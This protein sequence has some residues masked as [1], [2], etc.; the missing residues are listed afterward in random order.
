ME[1]YE[2]LF[3]RYYARVSAVVR[4]RLGDRLRLGLESGDIIQDSMIQAFRGLENY[5]VKDNAAFID[6]MAG[7]VENR[8]RAANKHMHAAKRDRAHEVALDH[9]RTAVSSGTLVLEPSA[10]LLS[11]SKEVA[12]NEEGRRMWA[13][14]EELKDRYRRVIV[15][16]HFEG[17]SWEVVSETLECPSPDAARMLYARATVELKKSLEDD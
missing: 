13:A 17:A 5:T 9:I 4:R 11:P 7:I 16:R 8:I 15:L 1:A 10:G 14:L 12:R 6:W 3:Q 2:R